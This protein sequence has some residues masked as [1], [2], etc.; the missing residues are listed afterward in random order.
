ML[1]TSSQIVTTI[2]NIVISG[3]YRNKFIP[4]T[5]EQLKTI[6]MRKFLDYDR[7]VTEQTPALKMFLMKRMKKPPL[8]KPI[9]SGKRSEEL[10]SNY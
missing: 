8:K 5:S 2:S 9:Y 10:F 4:H 1:S 6:K 3:L 7:I